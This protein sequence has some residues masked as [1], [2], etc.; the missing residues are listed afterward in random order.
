MKNIKEIMGSSL[1]RISAALKKLG[2][3]VLLALALTTGF[4]IGYYYQFMRSNVKQSEWE[5]IK[6]SE[7]TSVAINERGELMIIDRASGNYMVYDN[8]VGKLIF[9]LYAAEAYSKSISK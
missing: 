9:N 3:I 5:K 8:E 1:G 7:T 4:A 2:S 6:E